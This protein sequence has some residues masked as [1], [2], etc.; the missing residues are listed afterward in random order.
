[1]NWKASSLGAVL[2]A[3][4]GLAV[5]VAVGGKTKTDTKTVNVTVVKRVQVPARTTASTTA[6]TSAQTTVST[7][8][9]P[10]TPSSTTPAATSS[11]ANGSGQEQFL[12]S[13]LESQ[14][15]AETLNRDAQDV[16]LDGNPSEQELAGRTYQHA[17][18]FDLGDT[19]AN[20]TMSYQIPTPGFT[21]LASNAVGLDTTSSAN[22]SYRLTVYKNDDSSPTSVILYQATF[23]GPSS[24]RKM[25]FSTEGAT[26]L[27]FVWTDKGSQVDETS[28]FILADPVLSDGS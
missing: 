4:A 12:A 28:V 26:D 20:A 10:T 24:V 3:A 14:G 6:S 17:V 2:V 27:L 11:D 9:T 19:E 13:Y 16:S 15:G 5:G 1:V 22:S 8:T 18:A 25:D 21:R 7:A 23:H